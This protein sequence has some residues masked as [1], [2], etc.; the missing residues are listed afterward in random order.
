[1]ELK[2]RKS[3][4][5]A[6]QDFFSLLMGK[7][8]SDD[9]VR[10][11]PF[12]VLGDKGCDG[13]IASSGQVFQCYG[14]V[15]GDSGKVAYLINKMNGDYAKAS[16][17]IPEIMKE[18]HMVHNLVDG[19]PIEAVTTLDKLREADKQRKFGFVGF[20][21]FQDRLFMLRPTQIEDLLGVVASSTDAE[22]LQPSELR[23]LVNAI[24]ENAD[25]VD[26]D[27]TEI[28]PVPVEKLHFNN[29]PSHWLALIQG[30]W[31]N[32]HLVGAYLDRHPDPLVG[33][34]I[35]QTFRARYAYLKSQ[36]L[37]PGAIMSGLWEMVIGVGYVAPARYV[38][39]Q[40]LLAFLFESCDIFED[41]PSKVKK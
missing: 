5:D 17:A 14:A 39:A 38:A 1:L 37:A 21:G 11:R 9:F 33:E 23:D 28:G 27:V 16:K 2:L 25:D 32:A 30:G 36:H 10:I 18:W 24:A 22:N 31:Q 40:A 34:K 26:F 7:L 12:G 19:L 4:G 29:L 8:H 3:S 15:N 6:F 13:Y 35:A 41:H 20:D